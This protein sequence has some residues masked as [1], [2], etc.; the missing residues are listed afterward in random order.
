[1]FNPA[2]LAGIDPSTIEQHTSQYPWIQ[3]G[4]GDPRQARNGGFAHT[5][6]FFMPEKSLRVVE[7]L[8]Y[9]DVLASS[10]WIP[11]TVYF[12]GGTVET[13][14]W[15]K[16]DIEFCV[17]AKRRRWR[18]ISGRDTTYLPYSWPVWEQARKSGLYDR[19]ASQMQIL[20]IL[21]GA[22]Q[23]GRITLTLSGSAA[24]AFDGNAKQPGVMQRFQDA[25]LGEAF[26]RTKQRWPERLFFVHVGADVDQN[27][28]PRFSKVGQGSNTSSVVLPAWRPA[29]LDHAAVP[30]ALIPTVEEYYRDG[31]SWIQEWSY[32]ESAESAS[33]SGPPVRNAPT[34]P[35][36]VA[37]SRLHWQGADASMVPM[38]D[39]DVAFQ[40]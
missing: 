8:N 33:P 40:V 39:E 17:I 23:L 28:R 36:Q 10:G 26:R 3:W 12:G 20:G 29:S 34:S 37:V 35:A 32:A 19:L 30:D 22:E 5:G 13:P 4:N 18:A 38:H 31:S 11:E 27:G 2:A 14:G 9:R 24:M 6:G 1:M 21:R 15:Y 25:I 7:S 16:T